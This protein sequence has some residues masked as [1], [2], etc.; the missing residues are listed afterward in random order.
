MPNRIT[1][2]LK[3]RT[4]LHVII[5]MLVV[6]GI[7]LLL[8]YIAE[9]IPWLSYHPTL[10]KLISQTGSLVFPAALIMLIWELI[11]KRAFVAEILAS[12]KIADDLKQAG[13]TA[14]PQDFYQDV[15]WDDLFRNAKQI[16]LFFAY[17]RTWR[18]SNL[19]RLKEFASRRGTTLK[20]IVPDPKN[21]AC[22]SELARRFDLPNDDIIASI[23]ETIKEFQQIFEDNGDKIKVIL[24]PVTPLFNIYRFD[25]IA[26]ITLHKHDKG[27][28]GVPVLCVRREGTL[29]DFIDRQLLSL[30]H[31]A[32]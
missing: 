8:M 26:I 29:Y 22:I 27:R 9:S 10:Q 4:N 13:I 7:G 32:N 12:A 15:S 5:S 1:N 28:G 16:D 21:G 20:L 23:N 25:D 2:L 17:A 19:K 18:N 6:A 30:Y 14:T 11:N 24:A 31:W 3:E